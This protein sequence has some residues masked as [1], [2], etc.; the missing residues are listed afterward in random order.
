MLSLRYPLVASS[1]RNDFILQLRNIYQDKHKE[2]QRILEFVRESKE[3][4]TRSGAWSRDKD[5]L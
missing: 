2:L 5:N 3:G 4:G 1:L